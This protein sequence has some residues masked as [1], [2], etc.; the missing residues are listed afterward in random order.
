VPDAKRHEPPEL[1]HR[2]ACI[3]DRDAI[4]LAALIS[5]YLFVPGT[6]LPLFLLRRVHVTQTHEE[7]GFLSEAYVAELMAGQDSVFIGNALGRMGAPQYLILAGLNEAQKSYL[8][9]PKVALV[10]ESG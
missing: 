1:N 2:Y 5:S 7:I 8:L 6:Y 4:P 9:F 3:V 10:A